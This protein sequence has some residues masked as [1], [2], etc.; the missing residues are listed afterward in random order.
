[1]TT[2]SKPA[3]NQDLTLAARRGLSKV[4]FGK[5]LHHVVSFVLALLFVSG[6]GFQGQGNTAMPEQTTNQ[7]MED[8]L[9]AH[10]AT[11]EF[12]GSV[13][14]AR[15]DEV[16]HSGGYGMANLE[17][18][19][20]N[21]TRTIFRLASLTKP[22]T[23]AA[24]L[25]LQEQARVV[26]NDPVDLYLPD[27]P[28]GGEITIYHLLNH[29]SGIPDYEF[30]RPSMAFRNAVSL[31]ELMAVF[32]GLPLEFPPGSQFKYSNSGYVVLTAIIE[33]VSGQSFADYLTEHIFRPLGME[34]TG[35]DD[36][37]AILPGRAAGYTWDGAAYHNSE[38]FDMSN[39]VGAGGLVSTVLDMHR[40]DRALY[41]NDVLSEA[42]RQA[43]IT[44]TAEM[45]EGLGYTYGG[46][47]I[48]ISGRNYILFSGEINGFFASTLRYPD[49]E[50]YVVVLG[51]LKNPSAQAV[52]LGLAAIA[53]GDPYEIPGKH[54]AIEVDPAIYEKYVGSYQVTPDI[55]ITV[56]TE[57]GHLFVQAPDQPKFEVFPKSE[58]EFLAD[59]AG[60]SI[61]LQFQVGTDG[62]VTGVTVFQGDQEIQA[63]KVE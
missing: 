60:T 38:F 17:H 28:R 25:Q 52:A 19:V 9:Q 15:G 58:I 26:L 3:V 12:I 62:K 32:S 6:C 13:L 47:A 31:N 7:E 14:V 33:I 37:A 36:A 42:S 55:V 8:F 2:Q 50:L 16:V 57:E 34:A 18:D 40:W 48:E 39:A 20:P 43:Y 30:L 35:F 22:F 21:T 45:E 10:L 11:G 54:T 41:S 1:M 49:E 29:T 24:I 23:A 53:L 4:G 44:P 59:V 27:Y 51:N 61:Q 46:A 63:E 5:L 56:T